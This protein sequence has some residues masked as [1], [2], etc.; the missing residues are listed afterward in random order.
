MSLTPF[1][2]VVFIGSFAQ[3]VDGSLGM[4]FGVFSSSLLLAT[5][6]APAVAMA[7]VNAAKLFTGL[8]SGVSHLGLGNVRRDWFLPLM[9]PGIGG[10]A[11]GAYLMGSLSPDLVRP[12]VGLLLV[13]M[14]VLVLWRF[15]PWR[16]VTS[17]GT[18]P[19]Q[20]CPS[21]CLGLLQ[22]GSGN[23][24]PLPSRLALVGLAASFA[25]AVSGAYGPVAT[26]L[27]LVLMRATPRYAVGTVNLAEFFVAG[28]VALTYLGVLGLS[29]FR[30]DLV[31]ALSLGGLATAPLAAYL[32]RHFSPQAL[33]FFIGV[34]LVGLNF[35]PMLS[36]FG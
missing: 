27:L 20:D 9:L 12:W 7:T 21:R 33:G 23:G 3:M 34:G 28:T 8:A 31:A 6:F 10:G 29:A 5:G 36:L 17:A 35:R 16:Q 4:G 25:T 2:L 32:C 13:A 30:W 11:L 18:R 22:A 14:G 1:V 26:T 24:I 15:S 19:C